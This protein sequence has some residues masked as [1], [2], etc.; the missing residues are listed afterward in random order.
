ME[1]V[2]AVAGARPFALAQLDRLLQWLVRGTGRGIEQGG[3]AAMESG[4]ADLLRRRA[5]EI[6]VAAG[7]GDRRAAMDVWVDP[8]G[9]HDLPGRVD[10]PRGT[11]VRAA[12]GCANRRTLSVA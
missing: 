11:I 5:Q 4:A 3:R 12:P 10:N 2:I 8:S 6:L 7:E 1:P 9:H